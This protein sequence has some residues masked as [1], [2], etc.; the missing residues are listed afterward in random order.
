VPPLQL[1]LK[2]PDDTI[3]FELLANG[4]HEDRAHLTSGMRARCTPRA[5]YNGCD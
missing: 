3:V 2:E 4:T 5:L 1:D